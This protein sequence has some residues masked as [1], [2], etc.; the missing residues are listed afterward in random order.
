MV[1]TEQL[2]SIAWQKLGLQ[3]DVITGTIAPDLV[4]AKAAIDG[5]SELTKLIEGRLDELDRRNLNSMV[6]D[7]RINYVEKS[8]EAEQ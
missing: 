5:V 7:L 3:P 6:R 1:M 2:A 8:K 4:Q